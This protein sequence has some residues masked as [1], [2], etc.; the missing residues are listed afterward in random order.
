MVFNVLENVNILTAD[1]FVEFALEF[2]VCKVS[3]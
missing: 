2:T 3:E 1:A